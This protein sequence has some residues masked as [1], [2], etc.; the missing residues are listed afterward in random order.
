MKWLVKLDCLKTLTENFQYVYYHFKN[1]FQN[2]Y[3]SLLYALLLDKH[4]DIDFIL[5]TFADK[6]IATDKDGNT[7]IDSRGSEVFTAIFKP[8]INADKSYQKGV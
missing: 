2:F 7:V 4:S 3:F 5:P 1:M 8:I 6:V